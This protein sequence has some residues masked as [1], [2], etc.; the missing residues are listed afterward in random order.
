M[1]SCIKRSKKGKSFYI[2]AQWITLVRC[3]KVTGITYKV[4]EVANAE[5]LDFKPLVEEKRF[6]FKTT[7]DGDQIRW[8]NIKEIKVSF[9]SPFEFNIKYDFN[10]PD[11]IN[12]NFI[13]KKQRGIYQNH[14]IPK[15]AYDG[16]LPIEKAKH[17][18]LLSLCAMGL[19][20]STYHDFYKSLPSK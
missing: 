5:F 16:K 9:E 1:H 19:I 8:N 6:N 20:L 11:F 17:D 7:C 12:I 14:N 18:D 13:K 2:P 10:S 15:K 3:A 4:F